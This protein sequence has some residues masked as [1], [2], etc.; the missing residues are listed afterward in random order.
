MQCFIS[1]P[2]S[3]FNSSLIF[4]LILKKNSAPK[5]SLHSYS[6]KLFFSYKSSKF[7]IYSILINNSFS[8]WYV[9]YITSSIC[10]TSLFPIL[11]VT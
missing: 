9:S 4:T 2:V 11:S 10:V 8:V 5:V 6:G 3:N 7:L 1:K